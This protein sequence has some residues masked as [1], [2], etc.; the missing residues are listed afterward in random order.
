M[1]T[2]QCS[3]LDQTIH[4]VIS[5]LYP[6]LEALR[7]RNAVEIP[8]KTDAEQSRYHPD[9]WIGAVRIIASHTFKSSGHVPSRWIESGGDAQPKCAP[10][11]LE[12]AKRRG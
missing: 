5:L 1:L 11:A 2:A 8:G 3:K 7:R 10:T 9:E 12:R 6:K 4:H